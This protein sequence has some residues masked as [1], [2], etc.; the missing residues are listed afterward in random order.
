MA[1]KGLV[2][3][4]VSNP[5]NLLGRFHPEGDVPDMIDQALSLHHPDRL[6]DEAAE[7]VRRLREIAA[8]FRCDIESFL[9]ALS[10]ERGIDHSAL[11]GDR[12]SVISLHAAKGLEWQVVF[13]VGC[14]EGLIPCSLFGEFD[15]GEE[16]RLFYV[17]ATR[18]ARRLFLSYCARRSLDGRILQ[19]QPSSYLKRLPGG[20]CAPLERPGRRAKRTG[21]KQLGLF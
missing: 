3:D 7:A 12:V 9:D 6:P 13:I 14:E 21:Y 8:P 16:E 15:A 1:Y 2:A 19:M 18:A 20:L 5:E 4:R 11:E 10:L 17:G